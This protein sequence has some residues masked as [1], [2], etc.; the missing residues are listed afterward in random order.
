MSALMECTIAYAVLSQLA[1]KGYAFAVSYERGH[2]TD[3]MV[4][5]K[6]PKKAMEYIREADEE[7]IMVQ[8]DG[9]FPAK[10]YTEHGDA[11]VYLI[12]GNGDD[13]YH[14]ISDYTTSLE[15]P[16]SAALDGVSE[17]QDI[18]TGKDFLKFWKARCE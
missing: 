11:W 8:H 16:V 13:G 14:V 5:T 10:D 4:W 1:E 17:M 2:D 18:S 12:Y 15:E 3:D 9:S 7:H 6:D